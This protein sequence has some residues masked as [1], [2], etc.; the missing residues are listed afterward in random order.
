MTK[1][2][3][4]GLIGVKTSGKST[5]SSIIKDLLGNRVTE[6]ALAD[7]LKNTCAEVFNLQRECF[8]R[9]DIKETPFKN[10]SKELSISKIKQILNKFNIIL[11]Q[12]LIDKYEK[13]NII[14]MKLSTPRKI[15]QIVGTEVLR[16]TGNEDI[17]CENVELG[18]DI[19]VISDV[20]FPNEFDYF[21]KEHLFLPLY[22][23]RYEAEK[24][25][26][27]ESHPS[28][29]CVFQFCN[30]CF[31]INNNNTLE[32]LKNQITAFLLQTGFLVDFPKQA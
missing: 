4:I 31:E 3:I 21:K 18:D 30:K 27:N 29:K 26:T 14:N 22:I 15:A 13:Y 32:D 11:T 19:T 10:G 2:T 16:A 12:E 23:K 5:A 24:H 8:D 17:H 7:K 9:Q 6:S 20:R 28:E 1:K 25:V